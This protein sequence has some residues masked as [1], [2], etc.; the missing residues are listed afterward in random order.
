MRRVFGPKWSGV[1]VI[2]NHPG[3][4]GLH[5]H[6]LVVGR[7]PAGLVWRIAAKHGFGRVDVQRAAE[8]R[9]EYMAK[10]L[11]KDDYDFSGVRRWAVVGRKYLRGI[12]VRDIDC[13][14]MLSRNMK[15]CREVI[16][17]R[18]T[19]DF[20]NWVGRMT[21]LHGALPQWPVSGPAMP[22]A[23]FWHPKKGKEIGKRAK[24]KIGLPVRFKLIKLHDSEIQ[25]YVTHLIP[26]QK[27]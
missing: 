7:I 20:C 2:E 26:C 8:W 12:R 25:Q 16:Q 4:H 23:V 1:R 3:G 21:Q 15:A 10:Y 27:N 11:Q 9:A 24:N 19:N 22:E 18:M 17:G 5:F 6:L 13:D 14:S